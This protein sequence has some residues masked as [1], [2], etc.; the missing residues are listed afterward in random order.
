MLPL[1]LLS[2]SLCSHLTPWQSARMLKALAKV[3]TT[4][5]RGSRKRLGTV[6]SSKFK[7]EPPC[8]RALKSRHRPPACTRFL[9][10]KKIVLNLKNSTSHS[11]QSTFSFPLS[12]TKPGE[13][14]YWEKSGQTNIHPPFWSIRF[15]ATEVWARCGR[16]D[17]ACLDR[18]SSH[19]PAV[20]QWNGL[21]WSRP[22]LCFSI[23]SSSLWEK[24][25]SK[26]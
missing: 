24:W 14:P 8:T 13:Q 21:E 20:H 2:Q 9:E 11:C 25:T 17:W 16:T 3:N 26:I 6:P 1:N 18:N 10:K 22:F 15:L 19:S 5:F 12:T 7:V 23:P 4:C